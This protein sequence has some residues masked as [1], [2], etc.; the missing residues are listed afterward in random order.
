MADSYGWHKEGNLA[1]AQ[2]LHVNPGIKQQAI[3]RYL[4]SHLA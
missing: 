1:I 2:L 3:K 4:F